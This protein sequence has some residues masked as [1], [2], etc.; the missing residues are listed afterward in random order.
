MDT[1]C[2]PP[3]SQV[4]FCYC[5]QDRQYAQ[6][7]IT[8]LGSCPHIDLWHEACLSAGSL[9]KRELDLA[10]NSSQ[11]AVVLVSADLLATP[12]IT[13][14]QLPQLLDAAQS[15]GTRIIPVILR[16]CLFEESPLAVFR[17]LNDPARPLDHLPY[18]ARERLWASLA[19]DLLK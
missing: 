8:Q 3:G 1:Q 9:W 4:F 12:L 17:P 5:Q 2:N 15:R 18:S 11:V 13:T 10:L 6:R 19:R 16:A 7:F 14:H